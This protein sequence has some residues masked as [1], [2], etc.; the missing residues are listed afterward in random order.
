M[1]DLNLITVTEFGQLAP[2]VDTSRFDA[3]TLSGYISTASQMASQYLGYTPLAEDIV[4][5]VVDGKIDTAGDLVVFPKK[6]PIQSVASIS[7]YRGTVTVDLN[8]TSGGV[9]RF[10]LDFTNR[11]VRYPYQELTIQ[12]N[13]IFSNFYSLRSIQFFTKMSYRGGWEPSSLPFTIKQAV[14]LI[15]KDLLSGQYNIAGAT[16]LSQGGVSFDFSGMR[17]K[18]KNLNDAYRLLN[19]FRRIG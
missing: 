4:A 17:G 1:T 10:N 13:A 15:M 8:L 19:N 9:N 3:P 18:S 5:E 16:R 14:V 6:L 7:I 12:G 11:Y 2:E